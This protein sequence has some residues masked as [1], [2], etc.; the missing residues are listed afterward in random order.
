MADEKKPEAFTALSVPE[1]PSGQR[2]ALYV[3]AVVWVANYV[4]QRGAVGDVSENQIIA[5]FEMN[6]RKLMDPN[7]KAH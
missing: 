2:A 3:N 6:V 7:W 5:Q 1:E 4:K